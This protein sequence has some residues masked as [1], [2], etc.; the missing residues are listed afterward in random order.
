LAVGEFGIVTC[1]ILKD[2]MKT[3]IIFSHSGTGHVLE[4]FSHLY[5]YCCGVENRQF[6]FVVP[7]S[8]E[9]LMDKAEW[10]D[11]NR[12]SF[13]YIPQNEI[14]EY[15]KLGYWK[16][17]WKITKLLR[18]TVTKYHADRVLSLFWFPLVPFGVFMMPSY[19]KISAIFYDVFLR[20]IDTMSSKGII[21]NRFFYYLL[22]KS[23]SIYKC[24]ILND[25]A[26][27]QTLNNRY[28]TD[29]F[30]YL[31]DPYV[32]LDNQQTTDLRKVYNIPESSIVFLHFGGL[33]IRKGTINILKAIKEMLP[34]EKESLYFIFAGVITNDIHDEFY[35]LVNE[36]QGSSH[37]IVEDGFCSYDFL[38]GLCYA[39]DAILIPYLYTN[40][41][42]GLLGYASQFGKP[43]L[44]P[45]TGLLGKLIKKY[46][47]GLTA[48]V[49]TPEG[50]VN[51]IKRFASEDVVAPNNEYCKNN[52]VALFC[53][54]IS[55]SLVE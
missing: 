53:N 5:N 30:V 42:S 37:I 52:S 44:A 38:A 36:L 29:K 47:L 1:H 22:A 6:V 43:L 7:D 17:L 41:S 13:D 26:I 54:V 24:F 48:E 34:G 55:S 45:N 25:E 23:T 9:K 14:S 3:T 18:K 28:N 39:C 46:H 16:S 40:R 31:P 49:D 33:A 19:T 51:I 50:I 27:A 12:I 8:F 10:P 21:K 20:D 2:T 11:C 4:Y 15:L 35:S 32:P